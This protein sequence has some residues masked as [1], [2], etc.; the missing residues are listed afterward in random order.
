MGLGAIALVWVALCGM[1]MGSSLTFNLAYGQ[2]KCFSEELP[3]SAAVRGAVHVQ[4]GRGDMS[5]DMFVSDGHGTVHFHK[6]DINSVKFSFHTPA[7]NSQGVHGPDAFRFCVV[8]QVHPQA[9]VAP[10]VMR[11]IT[12]EVTHMTEKHAGE[13]DQLAKEDHADKIFST[14]STVSSDV[15]N[16]IE[17]MDE[18]RVKEQELTEMNENTASTIL[19]ITLIASVFTVMT[20]VANF[21]SLKSFFKRKKLA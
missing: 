14:F 17:K 18:L 19:S 20:G 12:L 4:S 11:R 16:L 1:G 8:N 3:A 9:A 10:G 2:R 21:M 15:D 7:T 6:S 13:I 5:L